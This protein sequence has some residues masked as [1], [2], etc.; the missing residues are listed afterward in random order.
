MDVQS[1]S[2]THFFIE[3]RKVSLYP[4]PSE[5]GRLEF[6]ASVWPSAMEID[7]DEPSINPAVHHALLE[8]VIYRAGQKRD[9]DYTLPNPEQYEM[10]FTRTFGPRPSERTQQVWRESGGTGTVSPQSWRTAAPWR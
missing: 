7:E 6:K 4:V 2:P 5:A 10:N 3:G 8:W 9:T 1:P